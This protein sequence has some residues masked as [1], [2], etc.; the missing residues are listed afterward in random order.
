VVESAARWLRTVRHLEASQLWHRARLTLRRAACEWRGP[1]AHASYVARA[2][3]LAPAALDH[4]GLGRVAALRERLADASASRAVAD[5]AL[6]GRFRFLSRERSFG[7][8]VDWFDPSLDEGTRLWKTLLHEFPFALDLAWADRATGD[9]RYRERCL[10]L[11]R[12]WSSVATIGRPG[13]ARDSW[14]A[15]A[16]ATRL[17]NWALAAGVLRLDPAHEDGRFVAR[18]LTLHGLFLRENLELDLRANHL[19]RDAAGLVFAH[20]LVGAWP[21]APRLLE[22]QLAEQVLEDGCHYERTPHYHA[23]VLQDLLEVRALLGERSPGWLTGAVARM[24]GFLAYLLPEDGA[25]PLFGD[26]WHGEP[27]PRA[28]LAEAGAARPPAPGVPERASG[29]VVLRAGP[30]HAVLR[31]GA[32]GPDFQLGHAH[33]D[34]LSFEASV[35]P[36]R[37]VTDTGTGVYDAGPVRARLRS[38]AA[39][40]TVQL[41]GAELLEAWGSFRTG[42]RGCAAVRG[43]GSAGGFEWLHAGHDAWSF[44]PGHPRHERLLAVSRERVLVLDAVL[45]AGRHV[46]RS[47]LHMHPDFPDS[48]YH[49]VPLGDGGNGLTRV[50]APL[51]ERFNET[52]EMAEVT[53]SSEAP[54][55]W[56]GGFLI[57]F[58]E[59]E[60]DWQLAFEDGVVVA[61]AAAAG[62]ELRWRIGGGG[63][64]AV[65]VRAFEVTHGSA[66]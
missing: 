32:H 45:G 7:D 43:R 3:A 61:R 12:G 65:T 34:L 5:A 60:T 41:D 47:A 33:A 58:G 53:L 36:R 49:V 44:L 39:H 4:P 38:T 20:E 57:G 2:A 37:L 30:V 46:L 13:Y 10:A 6:A 16:V 1:A 31:A 52:R 63:E 9:A 28:L 55:P 59:R 64:S 11:M 18:S 23:L 62:L 25:L 19:L 54:L 8:E 42:R 14:N 22:A 50:A 66:T 35:G 26:T 27:A 51:H 40:N 56:V 17:V 15:R 24:A 29:L 21:E 48:L